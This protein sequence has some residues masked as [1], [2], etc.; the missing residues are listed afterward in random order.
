[1]SYIFYMHNLQNHL[2]SIREWLPVCP[3]DEDVNGA[4][5][6]VANASL[7]RTKVEGQSRSKLPWATK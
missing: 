5:C 3:V 7:L 1:M 2:T 4:K 6:L